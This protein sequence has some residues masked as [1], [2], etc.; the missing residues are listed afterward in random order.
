M[1]REENANRRT[2]LRPSAI[3]DADTGFLGSVFSI[4]SSSA[5]EKVNGA[6]DEI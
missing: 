6:R 1:T 3:T 4:V 2:A 5:D